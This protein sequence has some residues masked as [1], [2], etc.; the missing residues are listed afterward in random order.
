MAFGS[1]RL[2]ATLNDD[3]EVLSGAVLTTA[4]G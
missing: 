3:V 2:L 1:A 4:A